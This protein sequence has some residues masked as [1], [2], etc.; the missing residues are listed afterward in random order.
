MTLFK[1]IGCRNV[2]KKIAVSE[3]KGYIKIEAC[4]I[5]SKICESMT[6]GF[7]YIIIRKEFTDGGIFYFFFPRNISASNTGLSD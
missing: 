5:G 3:E 6:A 1:I 7:F 2:C 4:N